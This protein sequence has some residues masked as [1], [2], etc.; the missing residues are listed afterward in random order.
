MA[1]RASVSKGAQ[2]HKG[3]STTSALAV[4]TWRFKVRPE[5]YAW[6]NRAAV[7][8]NQV[9]NWANATSYR[10]A[11]PFVGRGKFLSGFDLC[12]LSAGATE[13]FEHIGAA[14]IQRVATEYAARRR[15]FKKVKLRWRVSQGSHRSLGW[16]PFKAVSL[17]RRGKYLRFCGKTI[18]LFEARRFGEILKWQ[19]GSFAQDGVGA[20]TYVCRRQWRIAPQHRAKRASGL[21]WGSRTRQSRA[22]RS[23]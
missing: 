4:R 12:N 16:V 15:Q 10:V 21:I 20:G 11:R 7:E 3:I 2:V 5:S 8:V 17:H 23:D 22:M 1:V 19:D 6:L 13:Y 9:W 14:T 18:R